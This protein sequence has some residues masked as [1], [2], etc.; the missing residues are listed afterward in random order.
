MCFGFKKSFGVL[1]FPLTAVPLVNHG[2]ICT[3]HGLGRA[4][5]FYRVQ[6]GS[7]QEG[8]RSVGVMEFPGAE[9]REVL[10]H[11]RDPFL[12]GTCHRPSAKPGLASARISSLS[13]SRWTEGDETGPVFSPI[14]PAFRCAKCLRLCRSNLG[15]SLIK[16]SFM[17]T[18]CFC[19]SREHSSALLRAP[20]TSGARFLEDGSECGRRCTCPLTPGLGP[21]G[22]RR[23]SP[24]AGEP[25][26]PRPPRAR[27]LSEALKSSG[28]TSLLTKRVGSRLFVP[29]FFYLFHNYVYTF[30]FVKGNGAYILILLKRKF[31]VH[32]FQSSS[33]FHLGGVG[34]VTAHSFRDI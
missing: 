17:Q 5:P 25:P 31:S 8:T 27:N 4:R 24:A 22:A 3:A 33:I 9:G 29:C 6:L 15:I 19:D 26:R 32:S 18:V 16:N 2:L 10:P 20:S 14:F 21:H 34:G 7:A 12:A 28:S 30:C 1:L 11:P 23:S 13:G